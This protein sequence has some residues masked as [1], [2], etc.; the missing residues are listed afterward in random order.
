MA[1]RQSR[2]KKHI[3]IKAARNGFLKSVHQAYIALSERHW[4]YAAISFGTCSWTQIQNQKN[5]IW[6]VQVS[7]HNIS[8]W[9][10]QHPL[11]SSQQSHT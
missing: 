8:E 6:P 9:L 5:A 10:D 4:E 1:I 3:Y 2:Y 11:Q 7:I